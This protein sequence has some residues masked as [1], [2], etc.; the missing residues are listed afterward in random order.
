LARRE[1][2]DRADQDRVHR[3]A[4]PAVT[5]DARVH[6]N[7]E[8]ILTGK[9]ASLSTLIIV[10]RELR[11]K[12]DFAKAEDLYSR[13]TNQPKLRLVDL[14]GPGQARVAANRISTQ[15]PRGTRWKSIRQR[16]SRPSGRSS[17]GCQPNP[18]SRAKTSSRSPSKSLQADRKGYFILGG[19]LEKKK[20]FKS[21]LKCYDYGISKCP[22]THEAFSVLSPLMPNRL[23]RRTW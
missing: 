8:A 18:Q 10:A 4:Q 13:V 12:G 6:Y 21:A 20:K 2:G 19:L 14:E 23:I 17:A 11:T 1:G 15:A 3:G 5:M 16:T 22:Q 7:V 9:D